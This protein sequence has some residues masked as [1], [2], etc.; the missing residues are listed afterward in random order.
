MEKQT[1]QSNFEILRMLSIVMIVA[2]HSNHSWN[3][4]NHFNSYPS[5]QLLYDCIRYSGELGV[6]CFILISGYFLPTTTFKWK[7]L[8]LLIL[9]VYFYFYGCRIAIIMFTKAPI[10]AYDLSSWFLPILQGQWWFISAYILCYILTPFLR[11]LIFTMN[12]K[13][14]ELLI[15]SQLLIWSVFPTL[16][17]TTIGETTDSMIFYNRYIWMIF[18]Y[19]V[20]A[21]I[22]LHGLPIINTAKKSLVVFV[23]TAVILFL[24]IFL[25]EFFFQDTKTAIQFWDCNSLFQLIL[26]ILLFCFFK[27]LTIGYHSKINRISACVLGIY[28]FQE[29]PFLHNIWHK[30]FVFAGHETDPFLFAR[31]LFAVIVLM[32]AG[33]IIELCRK[34]FEKYISKILDRIEARYFTP[35]K[36]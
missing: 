24:Y 15:C 21:Y 34:P 14:F 31:I 3:I 35:S 6:N 16:F 10:D 11:K 12:K 30:V 17:L 22:Q 4:V 23:S 9:Q 18:L 29:G 20:G 19:F 8:F 2:F 25:I 5:N 36:P 26:S 28:L 13:E 1:R 32:L 33:I 27:N 7:K